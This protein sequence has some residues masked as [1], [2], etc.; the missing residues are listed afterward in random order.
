MDVV[1]DYIEALKQTDSNRMQTLRSEDYV[2][3][4]VAGDAFSESVVSNTGIHLFWTTWFHGLSD[5]SY[6]VSRTFS[7]KHFVITEW[8]LTGIHIGQL[9]PP[10]SEKTISPS[11]ER[12]SYR[13]VSIYEVNNQQI[14]KE[15]LYMDLATI[16][17][18]LGV[19]DV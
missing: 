7:A 13:G 17:V 19:E 8:I 14:Q 6:Q 9:G 18:E 2:M 1:S 16:W 4:F 5:F 10:M 12:I 15:T 11:G 3:D